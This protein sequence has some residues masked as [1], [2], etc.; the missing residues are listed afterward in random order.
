M[1][2]LI[3]ENLTSAIW[4]Q[5]AAEKYNANL[6]LY[7]AG[8]LKNLGLDKL[9]E[10]FVQQHEEETGHAKKLFDLLTDLNAPVILQEI[11]RIDMPFGNVIDLAT[12]YLEREIKTTTDLND[13]KLLSIEENCPVAEELF[14]E[15]IRIQQ[16]EYEE[17]TTF[18]DQAT[19]TGGDWK[20]VLLW[21]RSL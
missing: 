7:M 18:L 16:A 12:A 19:L 14:R 13:L 21:D 11:P 2:S 3:S 1:A 4:E 9:G 10:K 5:I 17:A 15:M 6:Y 20:F 8:Y